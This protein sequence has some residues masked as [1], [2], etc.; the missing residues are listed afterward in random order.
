MAWSDCGGLDRC[1][2]GAIEVPKMCLKGA[3]EVPHRGT[4]KA[5]DTHEGLITVFA[6]P[7]VTGLSRPDCGWNKQGFQGGT[8]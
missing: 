8:K 1:L 5:F 2:Q 6:E 4:F 3:L 7:Y